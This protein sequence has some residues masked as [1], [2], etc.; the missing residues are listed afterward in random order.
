MIYNFLNV[1]FEETLVSG[2]C[3]NTTSIANLTEE[4]SLSVQ[5]GLR[6]GDFGSDRLLKIS[7]NKFLTTTQNFAPQFDDVVS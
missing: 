6:Y 4:N 3:A 7:S 2:K 5:G 1:L